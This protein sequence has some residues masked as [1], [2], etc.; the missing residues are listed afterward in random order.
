MQTLVVVY[1]FSSPLRTLRGKVIM[2][3]AP[4]ALDMTQIREKER[5]KRGKEG[6]TQ[7]IVHEHLNKEERRR[8][9]K[10]ERANF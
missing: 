4:E 10:K 7:F 2:L 9:H 8:E 5:R 3:V 6:K 1:P